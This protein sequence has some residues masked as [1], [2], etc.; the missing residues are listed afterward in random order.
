MKKFHQPDITR[1]PS[2]WGRL[3]LA[4]GLLLVCAQGLWQ[5]YELRS[6][7]FPFS[8]HEL[9]LKLI[10]EEYGR[11]ETGLQSLKA[12]IDKLQVLRD[13]QAHLALLPSSQSSSCPSPPLSGD[14]AGLEVKSTWQSQIHTAKKNRVYVTQ[15]M[16]YI[17][18]MLESM[19]R[20]LQSKSADN[21]SAASTINPE[22]EKILQRVQEDRA[23]WRQYHNDLNNLSGQLNKLEKGDT[24]S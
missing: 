24:N 6:Y 19:D 4:A 1:N 22:M 5:F 11:I 10:K 13:Q 14:N 12:E 20:S 3:L 15:K 9:K 2:Q 23:L 18:V 8:Y 7:L 21:G 16:N 17:R